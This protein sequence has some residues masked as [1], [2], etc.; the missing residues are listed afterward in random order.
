MLQTNSIIKGES[1][2]FTDIKIDVSITSAYTF[3]MLK[4]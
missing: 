4:N 1:G 2:D 3:G